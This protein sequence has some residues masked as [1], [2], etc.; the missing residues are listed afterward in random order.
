MSSR[1]GAEVRDAL[2]NGEAVTW[3]FN[4]KEKRVILTLPKSLG[5]ETYTFCIAGS[6]T[7]RARPDVMVKTRPGF[8]ASLKCHP[9]VRYL[10][11]RNSAA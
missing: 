2:F 1:S 5:G 3:G 4:P 7:F 10:F 6:Y 9:A 8:L 11:G